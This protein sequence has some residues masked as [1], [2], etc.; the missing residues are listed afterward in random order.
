MEKIT[1]LIVIDEVKV[2]VEFRN[3]ISVYQILLQQNLP[4]RLLL[5]SFLR[6]VSELQNDNQLTFLLRAP[7]VTLDPLDSSNVRYNYKKA[8]GNG[9]KARNERAL[10]KMTKAFGG[11]AYAFQLMGWLV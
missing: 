5:A 1:V 4:V 2:S 9:G 7:R 10:D 6:N 11:Y 8:F 3:F